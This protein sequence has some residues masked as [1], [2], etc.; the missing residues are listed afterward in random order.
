[1]ATRVYKYGLVP[2][3]YP[4]REAIDELWR[5]NNLWNTLVALHRE[6]RENW[7][8]ARRTASILYSERMDDLEKKNDEISEA[9]DGLRQARMDEGTKDESNPRLKSERAIINR[10]K[11]E[12][13]TIY[14]DLKPLRKDAD[15]KID[16]KALNDDYR[17]KCKAA[18][19]VKNSKIYS[20][21]AEQIYANFRT[22]RDKAFKENA[23]M[24]FH[25]FDGTGYFQFR[26]R[27]KGKDVKVDGISV[28]EL[29]TSN[30]EE[31]M[32]CSVQGIDEEKAKPRIRLK[33]V[34]TGGRTKA[35]KIFHD[36]DWIY[37]RPLPPDC[38]IQNGRI[39]RTRTGDKFKYDLVLTVKVPDASV[40][41][42]DKLNGTIGID[43]GFRRSGDTV[44][45][46]TIM[47]D[48]ASAPPLE[49]TAPSQMVSAL[50]HVIELQS[51]LDDAAADLGKAITK[52]LLANPLPDEHPKF[53][54]WQSLAK[55]PAN[56]TLSYE[57]AYKV[58][59]WLNHEPDAFPDEITDKVFTWW[60]SY[61]RKYREIHN[62][63]RKQLVHRKHFYRQVASELVSQQKLIVL[64]KIN[65]ARFAET[66]DKDTK[67][68]NK[69]RAQ[70]FL[71]SVSELRDA[72]KN[73]ADRDGVPYVEVNPAYTS[74]TCSDC[75]QV[76]KALKSEKEWVCPSCGVVHDRDVN[77]AYNLA[78]MAKNYIED[79]KKMKIQV[80]K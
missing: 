51:E 47:S 34:L 10:L 13:S 15:D 67:L 57:K 22:A 28:N 38:Q 68:S 60:R 78:K 33:A 75:G 53:R 18:V 50:E 19:S 17:N 66:R 21:T 9:F 11:E 44:M 6:S 32:R 8:D 72:I 79:L 3:G 69:A 71:G 26:C 42:P 23:T 39:L 49:V 5:A 62:R 45:V 70:R 59:V 20:R 73:A 58:A 29:L 24:R 1:M 52:P 2:I 80:V 7:D 40:I 74:K 65:L 46:A 36:F 14:A 43:I 25:P 48:D 56:V 63:R 35:S 41:Q 12:R 55:R 76:N 54:L 77:A 4:P 30:F 16:K 64:E 27:K 31:Y 37:H 61:S